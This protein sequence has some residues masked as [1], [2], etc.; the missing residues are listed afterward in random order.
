MKVIGL[1]SDTH[2]FLDPSFKEHF[3]D[4]DEIW[5]LGDIGE[6]PILEEL[7]ALKPTKAVYGN[8]DTLELQRS[9][10]EYLLFETED[11]HFLLI[12]IAGKPPRYNKRVKELLL[13]D[14]VEVII[15]GHSHRESVIKDRE[16][17]RVYINPGAAG[18]QG[19]HTKR[20]LMKIWIENHRITNMELIFLG[21]K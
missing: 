11:I 14:K 9:L 16:N 17:K 3:A 1:I 7:Q 19:F 4:C 2:G 15:C 21:K 20:H 8:I 12:H 18:R 10:P 5:H 6:G 13:S